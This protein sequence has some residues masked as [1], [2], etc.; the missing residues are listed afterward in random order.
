QVSWPEA[1]DAAAD[2]LRA[3]RDKHGAASIGLI[4]GA[5]GTNED[6]YAWTML[7]KG[8]L[9]TDNVDAQVGD[10]LPAEM[11]LGMPRAAIADLE[12]AGAIVLLGGGPAVE[13]PG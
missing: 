5:R 13:V 2:Y 8:V 7:M 12:R 6:A 4:G 10:G 3:A 11:I 9:R 1:L